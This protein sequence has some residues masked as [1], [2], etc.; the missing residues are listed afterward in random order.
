MTHYHW[1]IR[2]S[3]NLQPTTADQMPS[4]HC[5][6][7]LYAFRI[8]LMVFGMT[9]LVLTQT[10][11]A[12]ANGLLGGNSRK[13]AVAQVAWDFAANAVLIEVQAD[14]RLNEHG[15]EAHTLLLG[16]YQ[17]EDAAM[18]YKLI[19]D[20]NLMSKALESGKGPDGFAQFS[21]YVVSPGQRSILSIDRAQKAKFVGVTAGYY[22]MSA[23]KSARLFEVPLSVESGGLVSTTYTALPSVLALRLNFGASELLNAQRL[24]QLPTDDKLS[25]PS[26]ID[27]SGKEI[28]LS[29][30]VIQRAINLDNAVK[31]LEK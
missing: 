7:Q 3:Q 4:K 27:G 10:G 12:V 22:Q 15:G 23:P 25:A 9:S 24:N 20:P 16:V 28:K 13:Q 26:L 8:L 29:S 30:E 1:L 19:A 18:F 11:C 31:K 6:F 2:I 17:M 5:G 14:L 21:R